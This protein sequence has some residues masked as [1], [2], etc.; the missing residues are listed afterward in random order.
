MTRASEECCEVYGTS[1]MTTERR[2]EFVVYMYHGRARKY[3]SA[4][5]LSCQLSSERL[6]LIFSELRGTISAFACC[7]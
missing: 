2:E 1:L 4:V 7:M 6:C 5:C 3:F